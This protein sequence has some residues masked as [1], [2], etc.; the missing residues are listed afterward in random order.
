MN[1]FWLCVR[2][3]VV[4]KYMSL[5]QKVREVNNKINIFEPTH[6]SFCPEVWLKEGGYLPPERLDPV[7]YKKVNW[8]PETKKSGGTIE[9]RMSHHFDKSNLAMPLLSALLSCISFTTLI[10]KNNKNDRISHF[11]KPKYRGKSSNITSIRY[12]FS[13]IPT[14]VNPPY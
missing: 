2:W 6:N 8:N 14:W 13:C 11:D 5:V 9:I 3:L 4:C 7:K 10:C 12:C 1:F